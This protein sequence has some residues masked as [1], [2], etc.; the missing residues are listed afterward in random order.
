MDTE[1][2]TSF[3]TPP[4]QNPIPKSPWHT[5]ENLLRDYAAH[6]VHRNTALEGAR[7]IC[8]PSSAL[9]T[10][11]GGTTRKL[12]TRPAHSADWCWKTLQCKKYWKTETSGFHFIHLAW[13]CEYHV[14]FHPSSLTVWMSGNLSLMA[15]WIP[16]PIGAGPWYA[17]LHVPFSTETTSTLP[18]YV[19]THMGVSECKFSKCKFILG[20]KSSNM[21]DCAICKA[22]MT[23]T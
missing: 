14:N 7:Y 18:P 6:H 17:T 16:I 23:Q 22:K 19:C 9:S 3:T 13:R 12:L 4:C 21:Y 15:A 8:T 1:T 2:S 10:R 11:R 20:V 5:P